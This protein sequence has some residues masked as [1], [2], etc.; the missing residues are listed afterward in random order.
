MATYSLI[1]EHDGQTFTT[2][3]SGA[4][5]QE[6]IQSFFAHPVAASAS[7]A[8]RPEHIIYVRPMEGLVNTWAA[9]A[10]LDG[11][12]VSITAVRVEEHPSA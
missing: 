9:S 8:L 4:T 1:V 11:R 7:P 2:Q 6:A 10:G 5:V 3:F 12:Y